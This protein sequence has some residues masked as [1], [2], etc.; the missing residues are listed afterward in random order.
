MLTLRL[1]AVLP[2]CIRDAVALATQSTSDEL[3]SCVRGY[4][5]ASRRA[6]PFVNTGLLSVTTLPDEMFSPLKNL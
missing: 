1:V 2:N 5:P 4:E 3:A 6:W